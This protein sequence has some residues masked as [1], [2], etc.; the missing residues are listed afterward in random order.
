VKPFGSSLNADNLLPRVGR[1]DQVAS[2]TALT[3]DDGPARGMR[4]IAV[5]CGEL[6]FDVHPDRALDIGAC[7]FR[8]VPLSWVS[9]SG[10]SSSW[11]RDSSPMSWVQAFPGGL[12]ATCGL[13]AFGSPSEDEGQT[14]PLHG[15]A[16]SLQAEH[17]SRDGRWT[18]D[19]D[20]EIVVS[21]RIRQAR[22][23]AENLEL[24]RTISCRVSTGSLTLHDVVTNLGPRE[25]PH[26]I[27]YHV[28]LG[29]PLLDDGALLKV[30][31]R[32]VLPRDQDA[33]AG[34]ATWS[35]F[36]APSPRYPEQVFRHDLTDVT[37]DVEVRLDNPALGLGLA[38]SFSTSQL[39]HLFQW[40]MLESGSYVLGVEPANCP[41]I[42]GRAQA[43]AQGVLPRLAPG[44]SR[45]YR[46][47]F[48]AQPL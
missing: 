14:F 5:R 43:R 8:G 35:S 23:F 25:Q 3:E 41:V 6:A 17:V 44:E 47:S 36:G 1:I 27:L 24:H 38:I 16:S 26:M 11:S 37:E 29:W 34:L 46:L 39:P 31:S 42:E 18:E 12:V 13:D 28:N 48:R 2:S 32:Q 30:P 15:R 7:S 4:R 45:E 21:G 19:G 22:L 10:L 40:K 33:E 9:P 20:Y